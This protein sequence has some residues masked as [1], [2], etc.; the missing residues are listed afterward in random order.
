ME[1][2]ILLNSKV[3]NISHTQRFRTSSLRYIY[4]NAED[5]IPDED[6]HDVDEKKSVIE[7]D[8]EIENEEHNETKLIK[9]KMKS[10]VP[11]IYDD[12]T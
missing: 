4:K 7:D 8:N 11:V 3:S 9:P 5:K 6:N 2:P 10:K 12:G 1:I